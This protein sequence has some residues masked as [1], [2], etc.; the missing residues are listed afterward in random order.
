[1][2]YATTGAVNHFPVLDANLRILYARNPKRMP[3]ARYALY[4]DFKKQ[5]NYYTKID[6]DV[7]IRI[8][9][10]N[11]YQNIWPDSNLKPD[12]QMN[13][14]K[15]QYVPFNL[16]RHVHNFPQGAMTVANTTFDLLNDNMMMMAQHA[17]TL[18][19]LWAYQAVQDAITDGT[20]VND[21]LL[22]TIGTNDIGSGTTANPVFLKALL[23]ATQSIFSRTGGAVNEEYLI[24]V[25]PPD[26]ARRVA[27]SAELREYVKSSPTAMG[28]LTKGFS[29][30]RFGL[31]LEYNGYQL[32]VEDTVMITSNDGAAKTVANVFS[33][34]QLWVFSRMDANRRN[35][36]EAP[37]PTMRGDSIDGEANALPTTFSTLVVGEGPYYTFSPDGRA[38][39]RDGTYGMGSEVWVDQKNEI[40][41][42]GVRDNFGVKVTSEYSGY[43]FTSVLAGAGSF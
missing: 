36:I 6:H 20:I 10:G 3:L 4:A 19:A 42:S 16:E 29:N 40:V 13:R 2:G 21:T 31:P 39:Y 9:G 27:E 34:D 41:E 26:V 18:R 17:G 33:A 11:K 43:A 1:M 24:A 14:L 12:G 5:I 35:G 22:A 23:Y 8:V 30:N 28:V 32:V 7:G 37:K 38:E 15:F 25:I